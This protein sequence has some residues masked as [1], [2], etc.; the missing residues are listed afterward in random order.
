LYMSDGQTFRLFAHGSGHV[1][2]SGGQATDL[3][4]YDTGAITLDVREFSLGAG[5][6]LDGDRLRGTGPLSG[7]WRD[8]ANWTSYIRVNNADATIRLIPEPATLSLLA[9][10]GLAILRRRRN[11]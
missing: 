4:A 9:L 5:L 8:G 6:L 1:H 7:K 11:R 2:M 3:Y 10:G